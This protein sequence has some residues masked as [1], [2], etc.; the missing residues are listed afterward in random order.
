MDVCDVC[1]GQLTWLHDH[2]ADNTG[3]DDGPPLSVSRKK[4]EA[5]S[6]DEYRDI[7]SRAWA[8]RREK[9]GRFGHR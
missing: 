1:G 3:I 6:P 8:T 4:M 5:K 7:R 9:Y 2:R